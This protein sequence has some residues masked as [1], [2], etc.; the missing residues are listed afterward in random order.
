VFYALRDAVRTSSNEP[1]MT[2]NSPATVERIRM[3]CDDNF[4][5]KVNFFRNLILSS[6][7]YKFY[8]ETKICFLG[9][10]NDPRNGQSLVCP[11]IKYYYNFAYCYQWLEKYEWLI[12]CALFKCK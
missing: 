2:F 5:Q 1:V 4:S 12:Y 6:D 3:A 9:K 8:S 10:N 7:T 11:T